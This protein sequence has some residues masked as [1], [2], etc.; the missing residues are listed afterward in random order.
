MSAVALFNFFPPQM[1]CSFEGGAYLKVGNDKEIFPFKST[2]CF[3]LFNKFNS[4]LQK[5]LLIVPIRLFWH[6]LIALPVVS[7]LNFRS[8]YPPTMLF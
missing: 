4:N 2:V 3:Y 7:S 8:R 6:F 1:Q 5:C